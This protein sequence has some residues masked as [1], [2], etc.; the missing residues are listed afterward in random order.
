MVR[1]PNTIGANY[2]HDVCGVLTHGLKMG[3][4]KFKGYYNHDNQSLITNQYME[5]T[6]QSTVLISILLCYV[7]FQLHCG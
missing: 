6:Y 1:R 3:R 7:L 5:K 2:Q 4:K